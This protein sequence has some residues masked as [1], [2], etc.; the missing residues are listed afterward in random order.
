MHIPEVSRITGSVTLG[1]ALRKL[2]SGLCACT[3]GDLGH[4]GHEHAGDV[5]AGSQDHDRRRSGNALHA[6]SLGG[7]G[8]A[9]QHALAGSVSSRLVFPGWLRGLAKLLRRHLS[10][11]DD[12]SGWHRLQADYLRPWR[13]SRTS[14]FSRC[15]H[16][17]LQLGP[18][19]RGFLRHLD[20]RACHRHTEADYLR[21]SR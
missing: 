1:L 18:C 11:L 20:G 14:P 4:A 15:N 12:A 13:R 16:G 6:A 21:A 3:E 7:N 5:L 19:V 10:H 9:D 8:K 2:A 17:G